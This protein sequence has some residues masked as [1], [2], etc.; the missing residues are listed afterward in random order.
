MK[1]QEFLKLIAQTLNVDVILQILL[2][3]IVIFF[4][5]KNLF[6]GLFLS[7]RKK[8]TD[9]VFFLIAIKLVEPL[10]MLLITKQFYKILN[11]K[12]KVGVMLM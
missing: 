10:A 4:L 2:T 1:S 12:K 5:K 6:L 8:E 7:L 9:R 3:Q 11:I